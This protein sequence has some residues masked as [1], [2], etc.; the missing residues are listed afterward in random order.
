MPDHEV[1]GSH[2]YLER[3]TVSTPSS[4]Q[5]VALAGGDG[6]PSAAQPV[7]ATQQGVGTLVDAPTNYEQLNPTK[8]AKLETEQHIPDELLHDLYSIDTM[9]TMPVSNDDHSVPK[10]AE[11]EIEEIPSENVDEFKPLDFSSKVAKHSRKQPNPQPLTHQT[12]QIPGVPP[13][14]QASLYEN[15]ANPL[16][17]TPNWQQ[18]YNRQNMFHKGH[19]YHPYPQS[20]PK[21]PK[22]GSGPLDALRSC[23][24]NLN[25]STVA[26]SITANKK[27]D[28]SIKTEPRVDNFNTASTSTS[29]TDTTSNQQLS[30]MSSTSK[31]TS[32]K[33]AKDGDLV[34]AHKRGGVQ[35]WQFLQQL[36]DNLERRNIIHWTRQGHDGEFKLLDPEEKARLWGCE[37]KRP[38]MNYDKLSR[39][40]R[41]YYEKGIM[42]KVLGERYVYIFLPDT[43]QAAN[44]FTNQL[45]LLYG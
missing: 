14:S 3:L 38:A 5:A 39:S 2:A 7:N 44:P 24:T 26:S 40:I 9:R 12:E 23:V 45:A 36:L 17:F 15:Y 8:K 31:S 10:S 16:S 6:K 4:S 1:P 28:C 22:L 25:P 21:E 34:P 33:D 18:T 19:G 27:D 41:Y 20:K 37:K 13:Y 11:T 29:K 35:L 42:Q 32:Q 30:K 43:M